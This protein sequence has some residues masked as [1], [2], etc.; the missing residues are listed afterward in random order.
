[1]TSEGASEIVDVAAAEADESPS[2]DD[3]NTA[4]PT[5]PARA[6]RRP[7]T[8]RRRPVRIDMDG[9]LSRRGGRCAASPG[10]NLSV[11]I[12]PDGD[13]HAGTVARVVVV[14]RAHERGRQ[15]G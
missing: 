5:T 3:A 4:S 7:R 10:R 6:R 12:C 9:A 2:A 14:A 8:R 15:Q 11:P 13:G 1:M